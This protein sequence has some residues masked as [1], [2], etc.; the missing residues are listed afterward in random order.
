M[1]WGLR[2][3]KILSH[4]FFLKIMS[5]VWFRQQRSEV[6]DGFTHGF[7]AFPLLHCLCHK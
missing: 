7:V 1:G 3:K 4:D 2:L 5:H 6:T